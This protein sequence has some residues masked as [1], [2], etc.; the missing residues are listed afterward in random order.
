MAKRYKRAILIAAGVLLSA[1]AVAYFL[2]Q[3]RGHWRGA[4]R[5]FLGANY[6]YV[7]PSV[8]FIALMYALR[9]LRWRVFLKPI[10]DVPYSTITSATC[11]GFMSTCVLPLRPGE[12]IR[13]YVLH[14]KGDISFGHAAG[15][16]MGLERV[17]DLIG[18][19]FL[20]LMT[21]SLMTVYAGGAEA[22]GEAGH[23]AEVATTVQDKGLVFAVL[24]VV[25]LTG[26]LA[27]A[28]LPSLVL[29]IA[30]FFFRVLPESWNRALTG[31]LGSIAQSMTF[32]KNPGRVAVAVLLTFA[33]WLCYPLSAY[34]LARGFG[35]ELVF[36]GAL[37]VQ[38]IVTA[39]VAAPQAPGFIGVF[40]V[41]AMKAV[42]VFGVDK[43]QAG[44]FA[45][46]LWAVNVI[47]ITLVGLWL[48][49]REGLSL[50]GLA[51]ASKEAAGQSRAGQS[52]NEA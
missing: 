36:A 21:W 20:L 39:A 29:K 22:S 32:L 43:A 16:A 13:P 41:A 35:L 28:F 47:P 1:V 33:L 18:V 40:S 9:V 38:V 5:A 49:R 31:F 11:I 45:M 2:H 51:R 3:M 44:G 7:V 19:C 48:L 25:G 15:T 42:E 34:C 23:V 52:E 30:G 17:F 6:L 14:K 37:L 50:K 24:T 46:M 4:G 26:L 12:I 27:L 10:K 8:S